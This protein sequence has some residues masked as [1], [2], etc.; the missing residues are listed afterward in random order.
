M[1]LLV[2]KPC[3]GS[4]LAREN[5]CLEIALR[6]FKVPHSWE[7]KIGGT[8]IAGG[9][10]DQLEILKAGFL[11]TKFGAKLASALLDGLAPDCIELL[12]EFYAVVHW[13]SSS[14]LASR[15]KDRNANLSGDVFQPIRGA[16]P[17]GCSSPPPPP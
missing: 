4:L 9:E 6:I 7:L 10:G 16:K 8:V 5:D 15:R 12:V 1:E 11:R 13:I 3:H 14:S 17:G 2:E